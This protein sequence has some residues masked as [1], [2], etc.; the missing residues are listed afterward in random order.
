[1]SAQ[2]H[3]IRDGHVV[4]NDWLTLA[5]DTSLPAAGRVIVSLARWRKEREALL[6]STWEV[7]VRIPNTDDVA[8]LWQELEGRPLIAVEFPKWGDGRAFSQARVLRERFGFKGELRATGD[9]AR[10]QLQFMQ[11]CGINAYE[12]RADQDPALCVKSLHDFDVAYQHA[13]D[14]LENVWAARRA[15]R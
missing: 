6:A 9:V 4:D 13:A 2:P 15:Q 1:M 3:F 7:G 12:L 10:D 14:A 8:A 11:R 5:D